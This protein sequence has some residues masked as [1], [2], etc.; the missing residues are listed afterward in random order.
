VHIDD[1]VDNLETHPEPLVTLKQG[2]IFARR[3]NEKLQE[4]FPEKPFTV[5]VAYNE[6]GCAVRFHSIRSGEQWLSDDLEGYTKEALLVL[7]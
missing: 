2:I 5:I 7:E 4:S 3:I 6:S 1:Y